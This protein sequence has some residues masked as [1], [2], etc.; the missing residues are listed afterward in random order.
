MSS[1]ETVCLNLLPIFLI[2]LF[3]YLFLILNCMNCI[4]LE[5]NPLSVTSFANISPHSAGCLFWYFYGFLCMQK[6]LS[7]IRSQMFMFYF[8]FIVLVVDQ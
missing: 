1:L 5:F 3:I 7:F 4:L 2:G 8:I 6:L